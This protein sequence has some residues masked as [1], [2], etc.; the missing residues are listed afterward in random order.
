MDLEIFPP[1]LFDYPFFRSDV[2]ALFHKSVFFLD[3]ITSHLW[4]PLSRM[5]GQVRKNLE[6]KTI[7]LRNLILYQDCTIYA[8][9]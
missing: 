7:L 6:E 1:N 2:R 8:G 3:V 5:D 4:G 9:S